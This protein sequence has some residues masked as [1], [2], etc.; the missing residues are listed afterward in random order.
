[1]GRMVALPSKPHLVCKESARSRHYTVAC[2]TSPSLARQYSDEKP[3]LTD[4]AKAGTQT[5][6]YFAGEKR[7]VA[8]TARIAGSVLA[9]PGCRPISM[10]SMRMKSWLYQ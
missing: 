6:L 9:R 5:A 3:A 4:A 7:L 1:M 2:G 10:Q 8:L